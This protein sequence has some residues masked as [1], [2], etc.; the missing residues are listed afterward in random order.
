MDRAYGIPDK[1][2][3]SVRLPREGE[4][5]VSHSICVREPS[6]S[7]EEI[8]KVAILIHLVHKN[9][10][11][12][13]HCPVLLEKIVVDFTSC[14]FANSETVFQTLLTSPVEQSKRPTFGNKEL[15]RGDILAAVRFSR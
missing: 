2:I 14:L 15:P 5:L 12:T 3:C 9:L 7:V 11:I 1:D 10:M 13:R 8:S 6:N 4:D